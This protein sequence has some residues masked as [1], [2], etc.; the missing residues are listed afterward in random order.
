MITALV[1]IKAEKGE[2]SNLAARLGE[3]DEVVEV[4]SV[5]GDYDL[6]AKL[7]VKEYEHLSDIVSDEIQQLDGIASTR[8]MM[9]FK[10]YKFSG[11][12]ESAPVTSEAAPAQ[13][14][15]AAVLEDGKKII[16]PVLSQLTQGFDLEKNEI[17]SLIDAIG[18]DQLSDVQIA[19]FL[20]SLLSKGPSIKEVAHIAQA[21]RNNCIP[22]QP[23]VE[24]E[25]TDTCGTGGGLTTFNISTANSILAASAGIP[26]AKHGSRSIASSSG[27]ADVLEALGV[28]IDLSIPQATRLIEE[29]GISFLYAPNFHPIMLKVFGPENQLGIKT[30]FFTIIGPLIN[31]AGARNHTMGV[32]KPELVHMVAEVVKEMDFNHVIVAHGLDGLDEI[33]L[34]GKTAIAEAKDGTIKRYEISPEDFGMKRCSIE[35]IAGGSPEFNAQ[36]IR[37]IFSGADKGPRRDAVVLNNAATLYVSGLVPSIQEGIEMANSLLD[38]GAA[39]NK[40]EELIRVSNQV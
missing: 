11:L 34:L 17:H 16:K 28:K 18:K 37:D 30:I 3:I 38:S 23:Q 22:F 4:L 21:M 27:S 1:L 7:Q 31:P 26:V 13:S 8:T 2:A 6:T 9:A 19:G 12:E 36:V 14:G 33:S 24:G 40:L 10:T 39:M 29:I 20:V 32:Y 5:A 25:I 15:P 35:D